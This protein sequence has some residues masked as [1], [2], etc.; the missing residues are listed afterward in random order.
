MLQRRIVATKLS[1][2]FG[3]FSHPHRIQIVKTLQ[4]GECDVN[5][6][7]DILNV[8]HARV[9]QHLALLREHGIVSMR[10]D[11]RHVYYCLRRD[12]LADW[13][14]Q[15]LVYMDDEEPEPSNRSKSSS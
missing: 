2:L 13:I 10:R 7:M 11:G 6:L 15:G 5:G 9:S 4:H 12:G 1:R 8:P 14:R 3:L